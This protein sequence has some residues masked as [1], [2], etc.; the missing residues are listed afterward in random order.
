MWKLVND[1]KIDVLRMTQENLAMMQQNNQAL[2]Q[3]LTNHLPTVNEPKVE[4]VGNSKE[5]MEERNKIAFNAAYALNLCTI[6]VS[7]IIDYNDV[8]FLEEEYDAILNN[9]NLEQ[10]P[11]DEALLR[12]LKQLLDVITFFRIQDTERKIMEREYKQRIKDAIWSAVPNL[13][14]IVATNN[15]TSIAISLASQIGIG[16]MNYRKEKAQVN[17]D[18]ERREW[19]LQKSAIE[20]FNGLRREL[21]DTAWRLADEYKFPDEYRLTERQISQYNNILLDADDLRRYERLEYIS[22]KFQAYPP[23]WYYLGNAANSIYM[24]ERYPMS[25]RGEYKNRAIPHFDYFLRITERNLLR[26]DQLRASCAL[27]MFDLIEEKDKKTALLETAIATSGGAFDVLQICA[28]S[29]LKIGDIDKASNLFK[30]LFN[31]DYNRVLNAQLLSRIYVC[32]YIDGEQKYKDLYYLLNKRIGMNQVLFPLP[33]QIPQNDEEK[34]ALSDQ[35]IRYQHKGLLIEYATGIESYINKCERKYN[36]ICSQPGNIMG[37]M[38]KLIKSMGKSIK[39]L[40]DEI[41]E[42]KFIT[43]VQK[44][45]KENENFDMWIQIEEDR[46]R[47]NNLYSFYQMFG[48]AFTDFT[49]ILREKIMKVTNMEE[50]SILDTALNE[51]L[52]FNEIENNGSTTEKK[53][54][55]ILDGVQDIFGDKLADAFKFNLK[56]QN[57]LTVVKDKKNGI[58]PQNSN[59]EFLMRGDLKFKPYLERNKKTFDGKIP[60]NSIVAIL[61]DTNVSD[62]DLIFTTSRVYVTGWIFVKANAKYADIRLAQSGNKLVIGEYK[63]GN[64]NVQMEKLLEMITV[65]GTA[66]NKKDTGTDE[67]SL[68]SEINYLLITGENEDLP[69]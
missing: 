22:D 23:F 39:L 21:F 15:P 65:L 28:I 25:L 7:Q 58:L 2:A 64:P 56:I 34:E 53:L 20:Q 41:D 18:K 38:S 9:L 54:S 3:I 52:I 12:I 8:G 45:F 19:E 35:F 26:E 51:F 36:F 11:K 33:E 30:M 59:M 31:E 13:S 37:E 14:M 67:P 48:K 5:S 17:R 60:D 44:I 4:Y 29:Y 6:S 69:K 57:L 63:Y 55:D 32:K 43:E 46:K 49:K 62:I 68:G 24:N 40:G 47:E 61:N 27:E 66:A 16:Y 10:M 42:I 1:E 50:A